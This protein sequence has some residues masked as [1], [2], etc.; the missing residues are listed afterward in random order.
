MTLNEINALKKLHAENVEAQKQRIQMTFALSRLASALK[1]TIPDSADDL[2]AVLLCVAA[3]QNL[4]DELA[5]IDRRIKRSR[6]L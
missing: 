3:A 6:S 1:V 4:S 5:N 2:E